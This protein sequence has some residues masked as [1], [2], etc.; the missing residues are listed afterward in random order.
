MLVQATP[1]AT[2]TPEVVQVTG[3]RVNPTPQGV[4]VILE[5]SNG[6]QLQVLTSS[7]GRTFVA[8]IVNT[9]LALPEKKAFHADNPATGITA[10]TVT[11]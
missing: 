5:T 2:A 11:Q 7:Y 6:E 1:T 10:V 9:Q 4:E 3:V 8:N